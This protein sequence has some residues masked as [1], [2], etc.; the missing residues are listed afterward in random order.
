MI[1]PDVPLVISS[2]K[3]AINI[4]LDVLL[5]SKFRVGHLD[6]DVN[7]QAIIR[8]SCEAAGAAVGLA[9][10]LFKANKLYQSRPLE[11]TESRKPTIWALRTLAR[12]GW[13]TF[14]ES[15]IRNILYLW[16]VSGIVG[17]GSDYATV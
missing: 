10:F 3:T 2:V 4:L 7:T 17:M 16:L 5:L 13:Y 14:V 1:R 8:L 12:Q 11:E 15:A 6:V 9:F